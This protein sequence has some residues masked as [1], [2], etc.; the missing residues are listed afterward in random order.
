MLVSGAS[1]VVVTLVGVMTGG[2]LASRVPAVPV[3]A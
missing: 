1:R 2:M 3:A